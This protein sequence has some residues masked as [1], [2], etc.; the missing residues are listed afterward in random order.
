MNQQNSSYSYIKINNHE[1]EKTK[2][3][4]SDK[5]KDKLIITQGSNGCLYKEVNYP[6][7]EVQI[8]DLSGAGDTFLAGLVVKFLNTKNISESIIYANQCATKAVQKRG[9]SL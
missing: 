4:I 1:Y 7:K 3:D 6:V 9:V 2:N 5:V 8:R